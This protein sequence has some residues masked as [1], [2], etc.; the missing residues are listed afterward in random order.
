MRPHPCNGMLLGNKRCEALTPCHMDEP[1]NHCA[2]GKKPVIKQHIP[3]LEEISKIGKFR[4]SG[5]L[6]LGVG[7]TVA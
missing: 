5:S 6:G 1:Q 3:F 2:C 7:R 4:D